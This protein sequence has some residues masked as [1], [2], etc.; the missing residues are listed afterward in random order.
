M[1]GVID[2]NAILTDIL[3]PVDKKNWLI[4]DGL[5]FCLDF[6]ES[7]SSKIVEDEDWEVE[8][9]EEPQWYKHVFLHFRNGRTLEVRIGVVDI[10]KD[11]TNEETPY[12][13]NYDD[14]DGDTT[15]HFDI[16]TIEK[17]KKY[18]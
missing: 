14:T 7:I 10:A 1:E 9:E 18:V 17:L 4:A 13:F 3:M 5:G 15:G 12:W 16:K 2:E 6:V 11:L 8:E